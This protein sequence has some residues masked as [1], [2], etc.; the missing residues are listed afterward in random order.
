[1]QNP[2]ESAIAKVAGVTA[3]VDARF[4][5][6]RG[7]FTKLAEQHHQVDVLLQSAQATTDFVKRAQLWRQIR[8]ELISHEQAELLEVYPL[9][10]AHEA[11]QLM[12]AAH[13]SHAA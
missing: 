2:I 9:L 13:A 11:T 4:K 1:M 5:G 7:V 10:E 3:A 8:K 6:L 12:A